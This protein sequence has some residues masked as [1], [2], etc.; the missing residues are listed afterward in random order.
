MRAPRKKNFEE[1][2]EWIL[3]GENAPSLADAKGK[4]TSMVGAEALSAATESAKK[5]IKSNVDIYKKMN[6]GAVPKLIFPTTVMTG[7]I[8]AHNVLVDTIKRQ[9]PQ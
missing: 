5:F 7:E 3:T 1:F 6:G 8:Q 2:H 4:A 9:P